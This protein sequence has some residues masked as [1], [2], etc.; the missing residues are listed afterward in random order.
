M[1]DID[2]IKAT[3]KSFDVDGDGIISLEELSRVLRASGE[4]SEKELNMMFQAMDKN[5]DGKV[6]F[7]EFVE[8]VWAAEPD[9]PAP[10][11]SKR[12][13]NYE[14]QGVLDPDIQEFVSSQEGEAQ[15]QMTTTNPDSF[16]DRL[17]VAGL[18]GYRSLIASVMSMAAEEPAMCSA[19]EQCSHSVFKVAA[20]DHDFAVPVLVHKPKCLPESGNA[21]VIYAHGGGAI[22]DCAET[23][24]YG[25][26]YM[27]TK[28]GV[29]F[30]NVDYRVAPEVVGPQMA[31][32]MYVVVKYVHQNAESLGI[33]SRKIAIAGESGGGYVCFGCAALLARKREHH[34]V[35]LM[36]PM[37]GMICEYFAGEPVAGMNKE[38]A[39]SYAYDQPFIR[40]SLAGGPERCKRA[41][42]EADS[43]IFPTMATNDLLVWFPPALMW[44]AE[45]DC[46]ITANRRFAQRLEAAGRLLELVVHPGANHCFWG[47]LSFRRS[48]D[49]YR[50]LQRALQEYLIA[51]P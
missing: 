19:V 25:C 10:V 28:A 39:A 40:E 49:W 16:Q 29:V 44:Q 23:N 1:P 45:F 47:T 35:R 6:V 33:D 5:G 50:D 34:L 18:E 9:P 26:S 14:C 17:T 30:F 2:D 3:F 37:C 41:L 24:K 36:M 51:D 43:A 13:F 7:D 27:A 22:A 31:M 15:P 42:A 20:K 21:C 4:W 12:L 8:W 48:E 11:Q 32:D 46:F 38:E